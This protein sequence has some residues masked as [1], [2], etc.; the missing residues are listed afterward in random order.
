MRKVENKVMNKSFAVMVLATCLSFS[1]QAQVKESVNQSIMLYCGSSNAEYQKEVIVGEGARV[2]LN[3]GGFYQIQH[4]EG[5]KP[6]TAFIRSQ[7]NRMS[8]DE[9]CTEFLLSHSSSKVANGD[10][11]LARVYFN[12]DKSA[13]TKRSE[14]V[15]DQMFGRIKNESDGLKVIG[16]TDS[17]GS[18]EYN[19]AL[20]LK[21]S[22][23]VLKYLVDHGADP[24]QFTVA[25]K[26]ELEPVDSNKTQ[27]GR[28]KN[29]RVEIKKI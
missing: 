21:R 29:R 22:D 10:A 8:I 25:S 18:K 5:S 15:L 28:D 17:Q 20:G 27:A 1:V 26:G 2:S 12:F 24:K 23:M 6:E 4:L 19:Y 3:Q 14:Y 9:Q 16:H 7:F 13:L 11:L